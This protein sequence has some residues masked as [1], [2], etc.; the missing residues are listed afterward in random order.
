MS[1]G[2]TAATEDVDEL[3]EQM[4]VR[5]SKRDRLLALLERTA[6]YY[7]RVLWESGEASRA[8]EYLLGRGLDEGTLRGIIALL[9]AEL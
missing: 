1:E 3:P 6:A 2:H 7:V 5:R 8:R 9:A 4:R